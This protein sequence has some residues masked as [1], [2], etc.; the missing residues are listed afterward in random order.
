MQKLCLPK[1]DGGKYYIE[2]HKSITN[3]A[4]KYN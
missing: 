4:D 3:Y 1:V 2:K